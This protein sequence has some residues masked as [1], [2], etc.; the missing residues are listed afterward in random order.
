[1]KKRM[2]LHWMQKFLYSINEYL[3]DYRNFSFR[4]GSHLRSASWLAEK[5][6]KN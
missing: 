6:K 5:I 4:V 2:F 1:M 3:S